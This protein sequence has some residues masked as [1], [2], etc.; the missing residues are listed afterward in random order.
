MSGFKTP[1]ELGENTPIFTEKQAYEMIKGTNKLLWE[2][3]NT[4]MPQQQQ[5]VKRK[6]NF[7]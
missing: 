1:Q 2:G 4:E 3:G 5:E 6:G 7:C